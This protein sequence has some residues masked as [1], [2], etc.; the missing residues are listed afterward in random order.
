MA[1]SDKCPVCTAKG[2]AILP[3]RYTV[4]PNDHDVP[5]LEFGG[6][7]VTDVSLS[8]CKYTVRALRQGF[9]YLFYEKS[10]RG[11]NQWEAYSV[12]SY[13]TLHKALDAASVQPV[14]MPPRCSR[15]G[16]RGTRDFIVV[17]E[18]KKCGKLWIAFSEY[19][20][21]DSIRQAYQDNW[22]VL[23]KRMQLIE[24]SKWIGA[25]EK[26]D[27][28]LPISAAQSLEAIAEYT[29][30]YGGV[31]AS[32]YPDASQEDGWY[33]PETIEWRD[34][35]YDVWG[36]RGVIITS[37]GAAAGSS[38]EQE[39]LDDCYDALV[40]ASP[41][42]ENDGHFV[43]MMVALWDAI[44][45]VHELNGFRNDATG[46]LA[47]YMEERGLEIDAMQKY[48]EARAAVEGRAKARAERSAG[49]REAGR[50]S[51]T[52]VSAGMGIET[53]GIRQQ[54]Y[55]AIRR[56]ARPQARDR[57]SADVFASE[58]LDLEQDYVL[59]RIEME[60]FRAR[61][62]QL[63]EKHLR[64]RDGVQNLM[65]GHETDATR[66]RERNI[67]QRERDIEDAWPDYEKRIDTA[68]ADR[69][70]SYFEAI[71]R[72]V[73]RLQA[74]RTADIKAWLYAP[75]FLDTLKDYAEDVPSDGVVFGRVIEDAIEGL[76]S[77]ETGAALLDELIANTGAASDEKSLFWRAVAL[78]QLE[79]KQELEQ[80][81]GV[82]DANRTT[83]M[84]V[85]HGGISVFAAAA[86]GLKSF[87]TL[88][89]EYD[90]IGNSRIPLSQNHMIS[91]GMVGYLGLDRLLMATG[92]RVFGK[93]RVGALGD[94]VSENLIRG[95][96]LT[97]AGIPLDE[98]R[99]VL[100]EQAKIE[101]ALRTQVMNR[102]R[103]LRTQGM[104]PNEA[105]ATAVD[106]LGRTEGSRTMQAKW[107]RVRPRSAFGEPR[108]AAVL[109]LCE[110]ASFAKLI[111]A[112]EKDSEDIMML[113]ASG[114][115]V[116]QALTQ[117]ALEPAKVLFG[118][119]SDTLRNWKAVGGY[120]G[121]GA[122]FIG[123]V[124]D[125]S[126]A[127]KDY[128]EGYGL[129]TAMYALKGGVG[130]IVSGA[131]V[132]SALSSST[133]LIQRVIG[134]RAAVVFL[135]RVAGSIATATV[136]RALV[137]QGTKVVV[138]RTA[139]AALGRGVL[140]LVGWKVT[141]VVIVIQGI[142]WY[143]KPDDLE[144]WIDKTPFGSKRRFNDLEQQQKTFEDA[145]AYMGL[146]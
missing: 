81:L 120:L 86:K 28:T 58:Y 107:Q 144:K 35:R 37:Q 49:F 95:I 109:A 7:R 50:M 30:P 53:P 31:R 77:E 46:W 8:T 117:V 142:I 99:E 96:F 41:D 87:A 93:W 15:C 9:L 123:A 54:E 23:R 82:L 59:E 74:E 75:L 25:P 143:F 102:W 76:A 71:Q 114:M 129:I 11:R 122:A 91:S 68:A 139:M 103:V 138:Q 69:F 83:L 121:G 80:A 33:R 116:T 52:V 64:N 146:Q 134:R 29:E 65:Q 2:L 13:G 26:G 67:A 131:Y 73:K 118:E 84:D 66:R 140:M 94:Y 47:R 97:R 108:L 36:R 104:N 106:E 40:A 62:S 51:P 34:T 135:E 56:A 125:L 85:A 127:Y 27:H 55:E 141:V 119:A 57:A 61:R 32:G 112:A 4:A 101:P 113:V 115:S 130:V 19:K 16:S 24:P 124:L 45:N 21:D 22:R 1:N 60:E 79:P 98:V 100:I 44:G 90:K 42:P 110:A 105:F 70:R 10:H 78:N 12:S 38:M 14:G 137:A 20:W 43:P 89:Y 111:S 63:E 5:D 132:L 126:D 136:Q 128:K 17:E 88:Y 48:G 145:L 39:V 18:P 72:D 92:T 6:H 133:H 3:A